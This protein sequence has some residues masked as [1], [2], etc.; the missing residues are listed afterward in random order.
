MIKIGGVIIVLRYGF[1]LEGGMDGEPSAKTS[2]E[3]KHCATSAR[4]SPPPPPPPPLEMKGGAERGKG[5][6]RRVG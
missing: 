3:S 2:Q 5:R 4:V 1:V 6:A